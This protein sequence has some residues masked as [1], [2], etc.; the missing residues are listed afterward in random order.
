MTMFLVTT[1]NIF[2]RDVG[3]QI[4]GGVSVGCNSLI[5]LQVRARR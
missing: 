3:E 4:R 5:S 1:N 2:V